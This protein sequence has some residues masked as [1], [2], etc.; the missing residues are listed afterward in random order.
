M[1]GVITGDVINSRAIESTSTWLEPLKA[2]LSVYGLQP[3]DWEIYRGDSF[4]L[5]VNVEQSIDAALHLKST[6]RSISVIDVRL[7]IGIGTITHRSNK[8]TESNG[9]AFANSGSAFER[10]VA[11]RK[12]F[13]LKTDSQDLNDELKASLE[14]AVI[15]MDNWSPA[16]AKVVAEQIYN[17][18]IAQTEL[19][20]KL[21]VSQAA[22]SQAL[23]RAHYHEIKEYMRTLMER[24]KLSI[25]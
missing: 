25:Q 20:R 9:S 12:S 23:Q 11:E 17:P 6:M 3:V 2:C 14:L 8:V 7:A 24:I 15:L 10:I 22:V 16:T 19:A 4:Q 18:N 5:L 21:N 1:V 13:G